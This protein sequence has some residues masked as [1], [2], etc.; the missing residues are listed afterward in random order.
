MTYILY[1]V[2]VYYIEMK[3]HENQIVP[4][5][6]DGFNVKERTESLN[7]LTFVK[8]QADINQARRAKLISAGD[9]KWSEPDLTR[10]MA[11][12]PRRRGK[13]VS[14]LSVSFLLAIIII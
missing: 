8:Q 13:K 4:M 7:C 12:K 5:L 2:S 9:D 1:T 10:R 6:H 3:I 11:A 14:F